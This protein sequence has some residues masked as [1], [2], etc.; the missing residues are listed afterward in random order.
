MAKA[1]QKTITIEQI[2]SGIG[3]IE[4]QRLC[5]KALG[6]GKMH[7]KSTLVDNDCVRGLVK[8]ISHLV[9]I[10]DNNE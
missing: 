5:L 10:E 8:K 1:K 9:R 3:C 4:R 6:L 7:R 2:G